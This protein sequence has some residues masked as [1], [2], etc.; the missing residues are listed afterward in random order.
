VADFYGKY[1]GGLFGGGG[2]G[3]SAPYAGTQAISSGVSSVAVV[4][5]NAMALTPSVVCW[6]SSS[7]GSASIISSIGTSITTAGFTALLGATTPDATYSLNWIAS[8]PND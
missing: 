2:G 3:S 6:L 8:V 4:F 7:N 1:N 5:T